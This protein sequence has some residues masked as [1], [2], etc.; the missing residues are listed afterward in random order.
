MGR[1]PDDGGPRR[2]GQRVPR[3]E[4]A[5][6]LAG[7]SGGGITVATETISGVEVTT[8]TVTDLGSIVPPG[9]VPGV[10][11]GALDAPVSFSI[12]G[13]GRIIYLTVGDGAMA[14][15][16]TVGAGTSLADDAA[17]KRAAQRGLATSKTTV[18][19]AVGTTMDL[20]QGLLPPELASEW[21]TTFAPYVAPLEALSVSLS[22]D[23]AAN[24]SRMVL[25]VS[26][27]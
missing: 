23:A 24:R 25:T 22:T 21:A 6:G 9:S 15:V 16:L 3:R 8:V 1:E 13:R 10:D 20:V 26:Q 18:Y 5:L 12:A 27:P 14:E 17:F 19:A 11:A 4:A 2:Q 7:L